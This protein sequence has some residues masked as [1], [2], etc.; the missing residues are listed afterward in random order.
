MAGTPKGFSRKKGFQMTP[1]LLRVGELAAKLG[2]GRSTIYKHVQLGYC[3][4][5]PILRKTTLEHY[6]EWA[7]KQPVPA[8]SER[9]IRFERE[10][11]LQRIASGTSREP[12]P[13]RGSRR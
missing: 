1:E 4:K 7:A 11:E 10:M 2:V 12:K 5:Y 8:K 13:N 9:T 6:L 3:L